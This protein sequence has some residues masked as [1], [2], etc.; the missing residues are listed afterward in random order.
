[1]SID[2]KDMMIRLTKMEVVH[3]DGDGVVWKRSAGIVNG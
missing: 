1:M 2:A 3:M